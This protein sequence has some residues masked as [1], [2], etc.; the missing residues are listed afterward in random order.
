MR[1]I[2]TATLDLF[3]EFG[4]SPP[5]R[6]RRGLSQD[7]AILPS[8]RLSAL[9]PRLLIW[10]QARHSEHEVF[11]RIVTFVEAS[12]ARAGRVEARSEEP[13][14]IAFVD[15]AGYTQLTQTAGDEQAAKSALA[16]QALADAAALAHRGRVVKLL[17]DGVMLRYASANEAIESVR[18]LM[19][20]IVGAGLPR[21]HAGIAAGPIVVRD[22]DVYGHTV[23]LAARIA[24]HATAGELL[25]TRDLADGLA[26]GGIRWE[27]AGVARLKGVDVGVSLARIRLG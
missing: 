24:A 20:D 14:A 19:A 8:T 18:T 1:R 16:L 2:A 23:N 10:L 3:D 21:A 27:D 13:P 4:G 5:Q 6:L 9:F 26:D 11:E 17:G 7:E 12:L 15:L 22:G 25:V